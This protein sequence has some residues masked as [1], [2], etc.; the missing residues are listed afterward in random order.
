MLHYSI[1]LNSNIGS[2]NIQINFFQEHLSM[3]FCH[4]LTRRNFQLPIQ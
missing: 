1:V 4:K 3:I 2:Q